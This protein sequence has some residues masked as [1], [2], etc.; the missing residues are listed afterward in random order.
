L[1]RIFDISLAALILLLALIP[2]V[3]LSI[4]IKITSP[5]P[6]IHWSK[7]VGQ[8]NQE[9]L[10]PKF[11][12]M[13]INTPQ[14]ATHLMKDPETY[15]SSIG[16]FLRKFSLDELPQILSVL[17]GDMTFVGPRPAL[18]NQDDLVQL[19]NEMGIEKL[20]PGITGWAQINGRD[21]IDINR[22][23][24]LET[25]YLAK[26][27]FLFDIYIIFI[28]FIKVFRKKGISH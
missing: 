23:I 12:T 2:M 14:L 26:K 18:F 24:E 10:M 28:T 5:G 27:G 9:F 25:E 1:K 21:E 13:K 19:R 3:L 4:L 16:R 15:L 7:R 8:N 6:I 17:N 11:R 22:K 20:K